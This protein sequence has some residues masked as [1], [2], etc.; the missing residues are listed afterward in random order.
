MKQQVE[1]V[2]KAKT[3]WIPVVIAFICE[4][5]IIPHYACVNDKTLFPNINNY[6]CTYYT[7]ASNGG[8]SE[9]LDFSVT[10]SSLLLAYQLHDGFSSPY[11]GLSITPINE[12]YIDATKYNQVNISIAGQNVDRIGFAFYTPPLANITVGKDD[13]T[14]HHSYLKVGAEKQTYAISLKQLKHPE[15]WD[16]MHQITSSKNQKTKFDHILHV[17]I[18]SAFS[19]NIEGEK[20]IELYSITLTRNNKKLF[21]FIAIGFTLV[22]L[23]SFLVS[24]ILITRRQ[25]NVHITVAYQPVGVEEPIEKEEEITRYIN[26]HFQNSELNLD[27][28][29]KETGIS[30]RKITSHINEV[31]KCNF[32]TYINRIR[33]Q[34]AQRLLTNTDLNI[35]E[36]AYKVGFNNQSHFNR[37]FKSELQINPT[38]YRDNQL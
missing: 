12:K 14:I 13:E 2:L 23:L 25:K 29:A 15:W 27:L 30:T 4:I 26:S 16:D 32:K 19:P 5:S 34:E 21:S 37:V 3:F 1:K 33:I 38:E 31:F 18:S 17:N 6:K 35:G 8:N 9:I 24:Y 20:A 10:D 7:D 22:V 28:I 11:V 36:I